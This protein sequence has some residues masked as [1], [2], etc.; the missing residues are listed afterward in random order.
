MESRLTAIYS[1]F[2]AASLSKSVTAYGA[3]KLASAN[4]LNLDKQAC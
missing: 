1:L 3:L 2:Q 4:E